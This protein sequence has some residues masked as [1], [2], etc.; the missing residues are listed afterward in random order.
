MLRQT[1]LNRGIGG[2]AVA[3]LVISCATTQNQGG[4]DSVEAVLVAPANL[5]RA[6]VVQVL[7]E[8]GYEVSGEDQPERILST[9]YRQ[10]I[11]SPWNWLLASRFGVSR[12][13]VH[14]TI[15]PENEIATRLI[16]QVTYE[17]KGSLFA[18]WRP[19]DTPLQQSAANQLRLVRNTLGLL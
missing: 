13:R 14:A 8:A 15:L 9:G 18:S 3:A 1:F 6:A 5:V 2:L 12:S 10:E 7:T 11:D 16:I 19:Y 17:S 4:L